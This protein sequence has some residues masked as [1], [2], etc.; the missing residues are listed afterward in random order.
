MI[1]M[2]MNELWFSLSWIQERLA[3]AEY[4]ILNLIWPRYFAI[5]SYLRYPCSKLEHYLML[6]LVCPWTGESFKVAA[7]H[8]L[9][10][11]VQICWTCSIENHDIQ[12][13]S[14]I[15]MLRP[16][17]FMHGIP[18]FWTRRASES[19]SFELL[20]MYVRKCARNAAFIFLRVFSRSMC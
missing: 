6:I 15:I 11:I 12:L 2:W 20:A 18:G 13:K 17:S 7:V 9:H 19:A 4:W 16:H 8:M 5:H 10:C 1:N 3:Q 14:S